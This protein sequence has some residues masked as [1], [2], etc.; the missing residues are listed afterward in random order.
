M[1]PIKADDNLFD[2]L[3]LDADDLDLD[4]VELISKRTGRTLDGY[5]NNP[6]YGKVTTVRNLVLFFNAQKKE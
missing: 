4:L 2:D 5:K 3:L 6:Y 1:F